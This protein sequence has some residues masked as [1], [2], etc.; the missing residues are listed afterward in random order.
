MRRAAAT[1]VLTLA[2]LGAPPSTLGHPGHGPTQVDV[3]DNAF[4]PISKRITVGDTVIWYFSGTNHTVTSDPGESETF[5]SDPG[6]L[7]P[8]HSPGDTFS[9]VFTRAGTYRYHCDIHGGMTGAIIVDP[10]PS[11]DTTAPSFSKLKIRP[12]R[13]W[14][15][16]RFTLSESATVIGR[17]DRRRDGKWR[18][19][20]TFDFEAAAGKTRRRLRI[21]SLAPG[22]YRLRLRAIDAAD[23][24]SKT[25][26]LK[27]RVDP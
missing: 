18:R 8:D 20:R 25:A 9:H 2:L 27:F 5:D 26:K 13:V 17:L 21:K 22:R 19:K 23:N 3:V 1:A 14:A 24:V 11:A 7:P 10:A 6:L 4:N 12:K 16:F 15:Y